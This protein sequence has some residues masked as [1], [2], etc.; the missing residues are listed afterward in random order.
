MFNKQKHNCNINMKKNWSLDAGNTTT[1]FYDFIIPISDDNYKEVILE[2]DE[3]FLI[4]ADKYKLFFFKDRKLENY[5]DQYKKKRE[6]RFF[7]DDYKF[8]RYLSLNQIYDVGENEDPF[9]YADNL[10]ISI[11]EYIQQSIEFIDYPCNKV[12]KKVLGE[13]LSQSSTD[14]IEFNAITKKI[15]GGNSLGLDISSYSDIWFEEV[16]P[17]SWDTPIDNRDI[18]YRITPRLNSFLKALRDKTISLGGIV[19]LYEQKMQYV[20]PEGIL[21][22][23]KIIYQEDIDNGLIELPPP[24]KEDE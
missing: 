18:A 15:E 10:Y 4:N 7:R 19:E 6:E 9:E 23:G 21:L 11:P 2:M 8:V 5:F 13:V 22:D 24:R 14:G 16:C 12:V 17:E 3:T 1:F 20:T